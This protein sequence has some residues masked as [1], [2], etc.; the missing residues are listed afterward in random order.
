MAPRE[1]RGISISDPEADA[2][3]NLELSLGL[4][5]GGA[6]RRTIDPCLL[7]LGSESITATRKECFLAGSGFD[8]TAMEAQAAQSRVR[9]RAA[10]EAELLAG[11]RRIDGRNGVGIPHPNLN[12][13]SGLYGSGAIPVAYPFHQVQY[14]PIPNGFGFPCVMPCWAPTL[15]MVERNVLHPVAC[16]GLPVAVSGANPNGDCNVDEN[17]GKGIGAPLLAGSAVSGSSSSGLSDQKSGSIQGSSSCSDSR[18]HSSTTMAMQQHSSEA[19]KGNAE[20]LISSTAQ[21]N[22]MKNVKEPTAFISVNKSIST[23][24]SRTGDNSL[25]RMPCVSTTGDGPSGRTITGFLYKYSKSEISIVCTCHGSSFSPAEFVKHA[26]G[27]CTS[28]PL[29]QIVVVP[30]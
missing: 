17:G 16:R 18:S 19:T 2:D 11:C 10:R 4:S 9:D 24:D 1:A 20:K 30:S 3:A 25:P 12:L 27:S 22:L 6:S 15:S 23:D 13:S 8:R 26:G 5:I 7:T 21:S 14:V 28:H 29:R